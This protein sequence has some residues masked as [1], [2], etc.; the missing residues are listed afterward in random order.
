MGPDYTR[1]KV[2]VLDVSNG[3]ASEETQSI[4]NLSWWELLNDEDLQ[5]LVRIAL[6]E[7]KDLHQAVEW[8]CRISLHFADTFRLKK[9]RLTLTP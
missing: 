1:L 6:N 4:A 3:S 9:V 2:P 7:N 5:K 8:Q